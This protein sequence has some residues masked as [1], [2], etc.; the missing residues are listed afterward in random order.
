MTYILEWILISLNKRPRPR[1]QGDQYNESFG[2][3][4]ANNTAANE[5]VQKCKAHLLKPETLGSLVPFILSTDGPNPVRDVLTYWKDAGFWIQY[6]PEGQRTK[7]V[8]PEQD[9]RCLVRRV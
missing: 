5:N 9:K 2:L 1:K 3:R 7:R 8:T 4:Y 6:E